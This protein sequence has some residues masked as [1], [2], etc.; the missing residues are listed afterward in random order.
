MANSEDMGAGAAEVVHVACAEIAGD[1]MLRCGHEV[2]LLVMAPTRM[3]ATRLRPRGSLGRE[4]QF[5]EGGA[6]SA[7]RE[8][9]ACVGASPSRP[10]YF[11]QANADARLLLALGRRGAEQGSG[12]RAVLPRR[13]ALARPAAFQ[14]G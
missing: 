5:A 13:E 10:C 9:H 7:P 11:S 4:S 12:P 1:K 8:G 6:G 3:P 2:L 14:W